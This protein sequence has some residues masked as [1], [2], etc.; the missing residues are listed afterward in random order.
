MT[1]PDPGLPG[2]GR[3]LTIW[4]GCTARACSL[5]VQRADIA[6]LVE[7]NL[8][9]VEAVSSR[10]TI[11]SIAKRSSLMPRHGM[12]VSAKHDPEEVCR[13]G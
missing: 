5:A 6:Q 2:I 11:R 13:T 1:R 8:P 10:L 7:R 4:D 3:S 9:K 12:S